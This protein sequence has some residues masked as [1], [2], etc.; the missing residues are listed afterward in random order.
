MLDSS[1]HTA[2]LRGISLS[3]VATSILGAV[4]Y[5][6][7]FEYALTGT[8]VHQYLVGVAASRPAVQT[9]LRELVAAGRLRRKGDLY[10]LPGRDQLAPMRRRRERISARLWPLGFRYGRT[11]GRLPYVRM[12]AVT[13]SLAMNNADADGDIDYLLVTKAGRVWIGRGM[14]SLS[15]RVARRR[16]VQ[17]CPNF[18]L[19]DESLMI[20]DQ[21][22]YT[23][24]ELLQMVPVTGLRVY[25]RMLEVNDWAGKY[26]PN[27]PEASLSGISAED[28]KHPLSR[29]AEVALDT[30]LGSWLDAL[31]RSR[32]SRKM[33]RQAE[34][35][36][37]V[38]YSPDCC[39][40]HTRP[41]GQR[42][43]AAFAERM[44]MLNAVVQ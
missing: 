22:L 20:R 24:H 18:V 31:E 19:S 30:P 44:E 32:L 38:V 25:R 2:L 11:L 33:L 42:V 12:V 7:V 17:I 5:A 29:V 36:A 43:L 35:L 40:D 16:G 41:H 4:A 26:L 14:A 15:R 37:E 39:K 1:H 10:V 28:A 23:A 8:Q 21:N 34:S 6:D 27:V 9:G 3:D 13:G